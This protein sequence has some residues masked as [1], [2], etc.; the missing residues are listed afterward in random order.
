[1]EIGN[2]MRKVW[3]N[4]DLSLMQI[5]GTICGG[6]L[7][8][9]YALMRSMELFNNINIGAILLFTFIGTLTFGLMYGIFNN[10]IWLNIEEDIKLSKLYTKAH[11]IITGIGTFGFSISALF[12]FV[13]FLITIYRLKMFGI[14]VTF[15]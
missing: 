7:A 13:I 15:I 14:S 10:T 4:M 8:S 3:N 2:Y 5:T 1:M 9:N 11:N 12:L 6:V